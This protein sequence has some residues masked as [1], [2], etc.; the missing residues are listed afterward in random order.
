MIKHEYTDTP[1]KFN[2]QREAARIRLQSVGSSHLGSG[3]W[4]NMQ[5]EFVSKVSFVH[6][7]V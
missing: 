2:Q 4:G 7:L 1:E 5:A 6:C 3:G